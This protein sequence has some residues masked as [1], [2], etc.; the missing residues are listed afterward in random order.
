MR[1][2]GCAFIFRCLLV[3]MQS[4][5]AVQDDQASK[6]KQ[7]QAILEKWITAQGGRNRL[8][9]IRDITSSSNL[10]VP[11]IGISGTQISY[12]KRPEKVRLEIKAMDMNIIQ[13]FNGETAWMKNPTTGSIQDMPKEALE[14]FKRSQ[15]TNEI[16]LNPERYGITTSFDGSRAID[17]KEHFVLKQSANDGFLI[18]HY[19][20]PS[21]Y[22]EYKSVAISPI[23]ET[24][25]FLSDYRDI[26]GIK[27]PFSTRIVVR[28]KEY[29][30]L[31]VTEYRFNTNL[32]DSLFDKGK[33]PERRRP[34]VPTKPY[35]YREE[36]VLYKNNT[37]GIKLAAT[38]TI[39]AGK[40]PFPGVVLISGSGPMDR[41]EDLG[42]VGH[43]PFLVLA[44][45]LTRK[46]II[47]LRADKRGVGKSEG[48]WD[49]HA[50][51]LATDAEA[52]VAFLRSRPEVNAQKIG[53]LGHSEG[54]IVAS[55]VAAR[56]S[57]IA[58]IIMLAGPGKSGPDSVAEQVR[59]IAEAGGAGYEEAEKMAAKYREILTIT[60]TEK[61]KTVLE[62]ELQDKLGGL[63]GKSLIELLSSS[64]FRSLLE[65]NP[66]STLKSVGCPVLALNGEKDVQVPPK[67]HLPAIR[68]ALEAGGNRN[69]EVIELPGLNHLFQTAQ[70][71]S[72]REYVT[73]EETM[74]P[75]ALEK[76]AVW[77]LN[78]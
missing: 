66:A 67:L 61:D 2:I 40:G 45:Y 51:D 3:C 73:I 17:G 14:Q 72:P 53:L 25:T 55:I 64:W 30:T 36:E 63:G 18:T 49:S 74:S 32:E 6:L 70:S 22:L 31:S 54:G 60:K 52:G 39:P 21:T 15:L 44:D 7:G 12:Y 20:D 57:G 43:K 29:M 5:P 69:F 50:N 47:V 41:D 9:Q 33:S 19:L 16:L 76:M 68:K 23:G 62:A 13:S 77:I 35:S 56:D 42:D 24:E 46:G 38:L 8:L 1:S 10:K 48:R 27:I 58:F 37:A 71:G 75:V 26:E 11:S 4:F 59:L 78:Q 65:Y 34:Q 28:G